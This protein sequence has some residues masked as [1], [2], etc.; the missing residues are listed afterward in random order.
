MTLSDDERTILEWAKT[1]YA[2]VWPTDAKD[3]WYLAGNQLE[4]LGFVTNVQHSPEIWKI[5]K[6]GNAAIGQTEGES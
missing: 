2:V 1:G 3:A 5:T 6:S 4:Q